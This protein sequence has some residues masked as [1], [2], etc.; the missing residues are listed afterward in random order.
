MVHAFLNVGLDGKA[1]S[2]AMKENPVLRL[3]DFF[4]LAAGDG[5]EE[6]TEALTGAVF[7]TMKTQETSKTMVNLTPLD[8]TDVE[9]WLK[10]WDQKGVLQFRRSQY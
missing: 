1:T 9:R 6:G 5:I 8:D 3:T 10:Y 2:D 4:G 7:D